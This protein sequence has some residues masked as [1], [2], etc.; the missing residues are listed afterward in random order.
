MNTAVGLER[1]AGL[2]SWLRPMAAIDWI[3]R[4]QPNPAVELALVGLWCL[5]FRAGINGLGGLGGDELVVIAGA[6]GGV[7]LAALLALWIARRIDRRIGIAVVRSCLTRATLPVTSLIL[8]V[9]VTAG[10]IDEDGSLGLL[11]YPA[12]VLVPPIPG[13]VAAA[14]RL[15]MEIGALVYAVGAGLVLLASVVPVLI[16]LVLTAEDGVNS[17]MGWLMAVVATYGLQLLPVGAA[18]AWDLAETARRR[19]GHL[20]APGDHLG[21]AAAP[22]ACDRCGAS[23]AGSGRCA[24]C[25][26][27]VREPLIPIVA[28]VCYLGIFLEI[29]LIAWKIIP[30]LGSRAA[31]L[32]VELPPLI[33]MVVL[34]SNFIGRFWWLLLLVLGPT[35]ALC[36]AYLCAVWRPYRLAGPALLLG[37]T[38]GLQAMVLAVLTAVNDWAKAALL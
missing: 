9:A 2:L 35:I 15:D 27:R 31:T 11:L 13:L 18:K 36:V 22:A 17:G 28:G 29:W 30:V 10:G 8:V 7:W 3:G 4:A 21:A 20:R 14:H 1:L 24:G 19:F 32:G 5:A 23:L 37:W 16:T 25:G 34:V 12:L 26:A 6:A 38:L 33:Q